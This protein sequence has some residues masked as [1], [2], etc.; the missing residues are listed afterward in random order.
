MY[1]K[2]R[3]EVRCKSSHT[4]RTPS[5]PVQRH[6]KCLVNNVVLVNNNEQ[7]LAIRDIDGHVTH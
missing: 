5:Q 4:D 3:I 6:V 2:N 1:L 7:P